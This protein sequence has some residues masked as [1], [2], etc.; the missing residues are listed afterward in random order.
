MNPNVRIRSDD[1]DNPM[2]VIEV[3]GY[4]YSFSVA[5]VKPKSRE[6]LGDILES[7]LT[8]AFNRGKSIG[9]AET[10]GKF[11]EALGIK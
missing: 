11:K 7:H 1:E 6:W 9:I 2:M 3:E 8:C 4:E 10:R 5:N